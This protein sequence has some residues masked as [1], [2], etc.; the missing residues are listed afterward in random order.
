[1]IQKVIDDDFKIV[2]PTIFSELESHGYSRVSIPNFEK[3]D[4]VKL[5][6]YFGEVISPGRNAEVVTEIYTD[7]VKGEK[8]VPLHNDKSYWRIPPRFMFFYFKSI[9]GIQGGETIISNMQ[10]A[11]NE[12]AENEKKIL[13]EYTMPIKSPNNRDESKTDALLV[14]F[15]NGKLTFFRL[16]LDLFNAEIKELNRWYQII[17]DNS[18]TLSFKEGELFILDNW[19][20]AH[21]RNETTFSENGFRNIFRTLVV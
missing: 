6:Y 3:E 10:S 19:T 2:V 17:K 12:L 7:N 16:R 13:N 20:F 9:Q 5:S 15:L 21:G 11:Y 18:I 8:I 4:L 14:N 1:M